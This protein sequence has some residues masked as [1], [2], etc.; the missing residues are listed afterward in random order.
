MLEFQITSNV[1][2]NNLSSMKNHPLRT[3]L[4]Y[5]LDCV[6][7]TDGGALYGTD[8]MDEQL[9]LERFLGL[10]MDEMIQM[11]ESENKVLQKAEEAFEEKM[12]MMPE[13]SDIQAYYQKRIDE[14][15]MEPLQY[16]N[17]GDQWLAEVE[18]ASEIRSM[19]KNG[20]PVVICGGSFNNDSHVTKIR[21]EGTDLIDELLDHGDPK[22]MFFVIGDKLS[23]YEKYLLDQNH[24]RYA[25]YAIVP[26]TVSE[27]EIRRLKDS[28]VRIRVSIEISPMGLYKSFAYELFKRRQCALIA[29]DGNSAGA[30]MIQEA[31]N[32][33]HKSLIWANSRCRMLKAKAASLQGYVTMFMPE[34]DGIAETIIHTAE[35]MEDIEENI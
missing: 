26:K 21:K 25:I 33:R 35:T 23:G 8:S 13:V 29:F 4:S 10:T 22:K 5:G 20:L 15:E 7:G 6:Q 34:T 9:A 2:L 30:N 31:V 17:V 12:Q 14:S 3:Y 16:F 32:G 19:Y 27:K 28:G 18:L 11:K 24:G 1:R